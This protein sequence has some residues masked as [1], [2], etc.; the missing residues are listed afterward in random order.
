MNLPSP[1][2]DVL[3]R[4][5]FA[6]ENSVILGTGRNLLNFHNGTLKLG[7][8]HIE[9]VENRHRPSCR[10]IESWLTV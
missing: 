2:I 9:V 6:M 4:E 5:S 3:S 8:G 10:L 7:R 1:L